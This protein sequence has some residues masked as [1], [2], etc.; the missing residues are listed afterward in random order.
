ML[1]SR[2]FFLQHVISLFFLIKFAPKPGSYPK[3]EDFP[4]LALA[5]FSFSFEPKS[6]SSGPLPR[7]LASLLLSLPPCFPPRDMIW[8]LCGRTTR[9]VLDSFLYNFLGAMSRMNVIDALSYVC[10]LHTVGRVTRNPR[11]YFDPR[12]HRIFR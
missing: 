10:I 4:P 1:H 11:I 7:R 3:S 9:L 8:G 2:T 12:N 6:L 5:P